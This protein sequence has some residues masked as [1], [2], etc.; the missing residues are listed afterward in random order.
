MRVYPDQTVDEEF[1]TLGDAGFT[2]TLNDRQFG[3]LRDL[4]FTGALADM[5]Y[6]WVLAGGETGLALFN[7]WFLASGTWDNDGRWSDQAWFWDAPY[8]L[9]GPRVNVFGAW[10]DSEDLWT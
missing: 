8:W 2:G 1:K 5:I 6:E 4:G 10:D 7:R 9:D 3:F